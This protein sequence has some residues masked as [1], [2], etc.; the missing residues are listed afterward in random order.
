MTHGGRR[1]GYEDVQ[2]A[3][4]AWKAIGYSADVMLLVGFA[5]GRGLSIGQTAK[6]V[7]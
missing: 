1:S 3:K 5:L 4:K 7:Y 2:A 6:L